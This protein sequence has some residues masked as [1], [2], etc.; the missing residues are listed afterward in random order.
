M[1]EKQMDRYAELAAQLVEAKD[2]YEATI[3]PLTDEMAD[4][5][6]KLNKWATDNPEEFKG[7]KTLKMEGGVLGFKLGAK[8]ISFPLDAPA[9]IQKKYL[10]IVKKGLPEAITESVDARTLIGALPAFPNVASQL[11]KLGISIK[12]PD[13]FF[14]TPK[15]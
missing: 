7:Q 5:K 9:D 4:L 13:N 6:V 10:G 2:A 1:A 11:L 3:K 15:K 8:A 12:Q 14:I